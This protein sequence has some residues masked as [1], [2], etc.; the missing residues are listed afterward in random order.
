MYI[1]IY[2]Y[3]YICIY[4]YIY[5][6]ICIYIY[7][8]LHTHTLT[9]TRTLQIDTSYKRPKNVPELGR[10][11][12]DNVVEG[13]FHTLKQIC[14]TPCT[15]LISTL[16]T[17]FCAFACTERHGVF[18]CDGDRLQHGDCCERLFRR[19][20]QWLFARVCCLCTWIEFILYVKTSN[21]PTV[22]TT[23]PQYLLLHYRILVSLPRI[24][25]ADRLWVY[26]CTCTYNLCMQ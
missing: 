14:V 6:Y 26:I 22:Y 12:E 21:L 8:Y 16:T 24:Y 25:C 3:M 7:I 1:Y 17:G 23:L 2:I 5:I 9:Y 4:I 18:G 15:P 11:S 10:A 19:Q 13:F 20:R